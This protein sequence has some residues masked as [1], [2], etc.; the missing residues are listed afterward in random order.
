MADHL[1]SIRFPTLSDI[2]GKVKSVEDKHRT[3][4][5]NHE[6]DHSLWRLDKYVLDELRHNTVQKQEDY[7]SFTSNAPRT[8]SRVV[9]AMANKNKVMLNMKTPN[10][11]SDEEEDVISKN[12]GLVLGGLYEVDRVR[13]HKGMS[14]LQ[15]EISWYVIHRGGVI[16]TPLWVPSDRRNEWRVGTPDPYECAWE[17][18]SDCIDFF[19]RRYM[20]D[21]ATLEA[22]WDVQGLGSDSSGVTEVLD[23]WW[24]DSGIKHDKDG[25]ASDK[26]LKIPKANKDHIVYNAVIASYKGVA[27]FLKEPTPHL[28]FKCTPIYIHR[29]GGSPSTADIRLGGSVIEGSPNAITDQWESIYTGVRETIGWM[30][31]AVSLFGLYLRNGAI[32]PY[33]YKGR[34]N[35]NIQRALKP[36]Q[37]IKI[38]ENEDFGPISQPQMAAEAKEFLQFIRQEWQKAGV[39]DVV[40]GDV[41]FAVSG[42]GMVQ[43]RGA[44]QVLIASFITT[45]EDAYVSIADE[46]TA[47]FVKIGRNRKVEAGGFDNRGK[48]F[49]MEIKPTDITKK[50]IIKATLNEGLPTD[51]VQLGNAANQWKQA[52]VPTRKVYED[53]F[54]F[55][56][57]QGL[58]E[59]MER[60]R[61][62]ALPQVALAKALKAF[63]DAEDFESARL[64]AQ[65]LEG[66]GVGGGPTGPSSEPAPETQPPEVAGTGEQEGNFPQERTGRPPSG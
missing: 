59:E 58:E 61:A 8:L 22:I 17:P 43:L 62:S 13:A 53:V 65:L 19:V 60:E 46:W 56:D 32:G 27:S 2:T 30:N 11:A 36:F 38:D 39:S 24:I 44:V 26:E 57:A 34:K 40:F 20:D 31:R 48:E 3:R 12:E 25:E 1:K 37:V 5:L 33:V 23:V 50:Y 21:V 35:K 52:G 16:L 47:Q 45:I 18:G 4:K 15:W 7:P 63:I 49:M 9:S 64:L 28:E 42:F 10:D 54:G 66:A 14:K 6:L 29:A 41:P 55:Q 51:P